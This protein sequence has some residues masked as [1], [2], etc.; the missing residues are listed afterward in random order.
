[1]V[2][3]QVSSGSK[4]YNGKSFSSSSKVLLTHRVAL[5]VVH[6]ENLIRHKKSH[7]P[8][9]HVCINCN[10]QFDNKYELEHHTLSHAEK[11][12]H[13]QS[14]VM[15]FLRPAELV[16]HTHTKHKTS[17]KRKKNVFE[18]RGDDN[19]HST[20]SHQF[21]GYKA[22]ELIQ[23]RISRS[24][25]RN[26]NNALMSTTRAQT[27]ANSTAANINQVSWKSVKTF[28][29]SQ[30]N[31]KSASDSAMAQTKI[32]QSAASSAITANVVS[33]FTP[34]RLRLKDPKL[35]TLPIVVV[36]KYNPEYQ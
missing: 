22:K 19:T 28:E 16:E 2:Y 26:I 35:L 8:Q 9:L 6:R 5:S 25:T 24:S 21:N 3:Y 14:C 34:K 33:K 15:S 23:P 7:R 4:I 29:E 11:S 17:T 10:S 12:Y 30:Q 18:R 36:E 31:M 1:M 20:K 27:L 32:K 13:C